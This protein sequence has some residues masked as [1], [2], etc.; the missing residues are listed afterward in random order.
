MTVTE[1]LLNRAHNKCELCNSNSHLST[2]TLPPESVSAPEK[3]VLLCD[4]CLSLIETPSSN[5]NHFRCLTESMWS[6]HSAVQ[7]LA[8]RLLKKL[9]S[10]DWA[11]DLLGQLYL[12]DALLAFAE[13]IFKSESVEN[14]VT[15][16]KD[17][18]GNILLDGDSVTLIKDLDVKGANFTAKRGTIVK[19]IVLTPNPE[20]IE[21]RVNG[22]QIVLLTCFLKKV[23]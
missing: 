23:S 8:W 13:S 4:T 3:S 19:N 12:D 5:P 2:Y 6:E 1:T 21:G 14:A 9:S 11:Q 7:I 16:T 15:P 10:F 20:H 17:S 22:T 18:N